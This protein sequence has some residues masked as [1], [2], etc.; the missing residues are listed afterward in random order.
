VT[1]LSP[2]IL[3]YYDEE[4]I[5]RIAEKHGYGEREALALFLHSRTYQMLADPEM[6]MTQFGPDGIFDIWET[7]RITG[8]PLRSDYLRMD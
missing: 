4:V 6:R 7:E 5:R 2:D 3:D 8:D 1:R